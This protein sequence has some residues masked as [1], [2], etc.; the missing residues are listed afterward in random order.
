MVRWLNLKYLQVIIDNYPFQKN[1][2]NKL[3]IIYKIF[4]NFILFIIQNIQNRLEYLEI[5]YN[6]NFFFTKNFR[7]LINIL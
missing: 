4:I 1:K 5:L 6:L 7:F 3:L 2:K